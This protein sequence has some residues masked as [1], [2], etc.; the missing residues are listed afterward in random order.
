M[1]DL[2]T[3]IHMY[4]DLHL[5]VEHYYQTYR[6]WTG[7]VLKDQLSWFPFLGHATLHVLSQSLKGLMTKLYMS[8]FTLTGQ[9][10]T[11]TQTLSLSCTG[12][13]DSA[14]VVSENQWSTNL[15]VTNQQ[16]WTNTEVVVSFANPMIPP[17]SPT[18]PL[19]ASYAVTLSMV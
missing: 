14:T 18:Q 1:L 15:L 5:F 7:Q 2:E 8:V 13:R 17:K 6:R 11:H 3:C 19:A 4:H 12:V 16:F 10:H 9:T